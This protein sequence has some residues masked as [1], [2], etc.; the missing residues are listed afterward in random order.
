MTK[1]YGSKWRVLA[2]RKDGPPVDI[3]NDGVFD[4]L[5]LENILHLEQMDNR[6]WWMQLGDASVWIRIPAK[7]APQISIEF[8]E[9]GPVAKWTINGKPMEK[10]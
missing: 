4:E 1:P 8:D 5:V 3:E 9:Y 10:R 7:G 2:H 6:V